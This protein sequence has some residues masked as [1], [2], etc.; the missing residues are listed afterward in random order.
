MDG[1]AIRTQLPI[2]VDLDEVRKVLS[3]ALRREADLAG[4]RRAYF[5]RLCRA[6]EQQYRM[7]SDEF[8]RQFESGVLGD[9]KVYFD[10]YAAKHGFD[11]WER[12]RRILSLG[13]RAASSRR[14][15]L[16]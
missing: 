4:V 14:F 8:L 3:S 6:F 10:W 16:S 12:R 7:S 11:L 15:L 1:I 9:E 5:E 13:Q 2:T